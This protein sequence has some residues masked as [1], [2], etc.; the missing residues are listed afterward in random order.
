MKRILMVLIA[1]AALP[2]ASVAWAQEPAKPAEPAAGKPDCS[3]QKTAYDAAVTESK[4][5]P[6]LSSCADKKGKEKTECEKPLKDQA[7]ESAKAAKEKAKTA[8]HDL[9]C[10][11]NPKKKGCAA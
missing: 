2:L 3:T 9:D 1:S 5:K 10:C 11:K 8:K 4:A 7:K 6:D